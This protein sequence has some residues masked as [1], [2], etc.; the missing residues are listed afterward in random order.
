MN[1]MSNAMSRL[2][3]TTKAIGDTILDTTGD[4]ENARQSIE[5]LKEE[6][7]AW[8]GPVTES[9]IR[10]FIS[11]KEGRAGQQVGGWKHSR[12]FLSGLEEGLVHL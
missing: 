1:V 2:A 12:T 3:T 10:H 9:S 4:F 6:F 7:R 5:S 8:N 11:K